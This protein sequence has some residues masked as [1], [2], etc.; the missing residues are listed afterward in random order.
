MPPPPHT[1]TC[2]P[3]SLC[4]GLLQMLIASWKIEHGWINMLLQQ[5]FPDSN[6]SCDTTSCNG[7]KLEEEESHF[8]AYSVAKSQL[9]DVQ[10]AVIVYW[11]DSRI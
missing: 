4:V 1:A 5:N 10:V 9:V 11:G 2:T 3:L 7:A 8:H 6:I